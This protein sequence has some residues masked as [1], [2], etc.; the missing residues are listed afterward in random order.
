MAEFQGALRKN[1]ADK[2]KADATVYGI[3]TC[4]NGQITIVPKRPARK[5]ASGAFR[6][7]IP[8]GELS[9]YLENALTDSFFR[10]MVLEGSESTLLRVCRYLSRDLMPFIATEIVVNDQIQLLARS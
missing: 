9:D 2:A 5:M 10:K 1:D 7:S 4:E 8:I 3:S 6:K